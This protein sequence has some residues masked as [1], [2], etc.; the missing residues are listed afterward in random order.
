VAGP[1]RSRP[2]T[3]HFRR[4][5]AP[6]GAGDVQFF[7]VLGLIVTLSGSYLVRQ[8]LRRSLAEQPTADLRDAADD[9]DTGL[10]AA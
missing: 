8:F 2:A 9:A 1:G 10:K 7:I 6:G 3:I 4:T 5:G